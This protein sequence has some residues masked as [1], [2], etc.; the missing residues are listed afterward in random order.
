[1]DE[2]L[3][4]PSPSLEERIESAKRRA[5]QVRIKIQQDLV[6]RKHPFTHEC[7]RQKN[8]GNSQGFWFFR[9]EPD[10]NPLQAT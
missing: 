5:H 1:M 7:M 9:R 6:S 10:Q 8:S 3:K 4:N 2:Q